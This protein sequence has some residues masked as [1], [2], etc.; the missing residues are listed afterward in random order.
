LDKRELTRLAN[1]AGFP[2]ATPSEVN[3][4]LYTLSDVESR[5]GPTPRPIWFPI[6]GADEPR[7]GSTGPRGP[8][9]G[10]TKN[11]RDLLGLYPWQRRALDA[12][13]QGS[14]QGVVEAVTGAGK[15]RLALAAAGETLA[16][17]GRV[18]IIVPTKDLMRQW[19]DQVVDMLIKRAGLQP[20]IAMMGDGSSE[21][22]ASCDILIATVHSGSRYPLE[23]SPGSLLIADECHHYGAASWGEVLEEGFT[24]RLGLTATYEREDNGIRD[25]LDPYFGGVCYSAGY[26]EAL[27]DGVIAPF[28]LGFAG[29]QFGAEE[30]EIY[31]DAA[32]KAGRYRGRLIRDWGLPAEPFGEFMKAVN[33]LRHSGTLEGSKLAGFYL[34]AFTKRRKVMAEAGAKLDLVGQLAPAVRSADRTIVFAQT[35]AAAWAVVERLRAMG[36][37]GAVLTSDMDMDDRNGVFAA[38]EDGTHELVAAPK[39]LD[40]GIDVPAADLA[41]I[42]AT[43]RSK[44]Q[45]IQRM[46][47]VIRVKPD[48][49]LARVVILYVQG[50]AEDPDEGAHEDFLEVVT[51]AA[52]DVRSFPPSG[53][54]LRLIA[55]LNDWKAKAGP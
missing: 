10:G 26:D 52:T 17:R 14:R 8:H 40:E 11:F 24:M 33:R 39:L 31:D 7:S 4:V 49:R 34:S 44:R 27:D 41:I 18:A 32:E 12:W 51:D 1:A 23:P 6:G 16:R 54:T 13:E 30:Q 47:R 36:I 5:P 42:V 15:T 35:K 53:Q 38:F 50:T 25:Y 22:L 48:G 43:S 29:V 19:R 3:Q 37:A 46:G 9:S 28:K 21:T 55:Y 45:L 2:D 20:K